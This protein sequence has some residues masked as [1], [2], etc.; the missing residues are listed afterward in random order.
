MRVSLAARVLLPSAAAM[1]VLL[2][3]GVDAVSVSICLM[4]AGCMEYRGGRQ[5]L[6]LVLFPAFLAL[7]AGSSPDFQ[8]ALVLAGAATG[9]V[10]SQSPVSRL[11]LS[12][13]VLLTAL[14]GP[15]SGL[16]PLVPFAL[17]S[18]PAAVR[19]HR[20][21][22]IAA[23]TVLVVVLGG[24][25][26]AE[27]PARLHG[28][29]IRSE[30]SI[31]WDHSRSL[32]LSAPSLVLEAGGRRPATLHLRLSAGGTRDTEPVGR[33]VSGDTMFA[34][35]PGENLIVFR[36]PEMPVEITLYRNWRPFNHPV[37]HFTG[38]EARCE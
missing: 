20:A 18:M 32:D 11:L 14:I 4:L 30:G 28:S 24:L 35:M 17:V 38:A 25:P 13:A 36:D 10:M 37:V 34:V 23:G 33:A 8:A 29:E 26:L 19:R 27:V 15:L 2:M 31:T 22:L 7:L 12:L 9:L 21:A 5:G 16:L 3:R 1:S 6:V